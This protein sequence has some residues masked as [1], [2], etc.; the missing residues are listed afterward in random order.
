[1]RSLCIIILLALSTAAS[2]RPVPDLVCRETHFVFVDPK[3]LGVQEQGSQTIY[4]FKSGSLYITPTD[5]SEYLYNKVSEVEPMRY[6]SGHKV[7]QFESDGSNFHTAILVH[8]YR[9]EVRV[10]RATCSQP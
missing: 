10:S 8:A 6:T 1:M 7:I 3:S 2:A 9:D 5:R 4:R